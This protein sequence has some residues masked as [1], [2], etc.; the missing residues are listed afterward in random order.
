ME[1]NLHDALGVAR[2]L[3]LEPYLVAGGGAVEMAVSQL[4]QEK[5]KSVTGVKQWP[6]TALATALE[7]RSAQSFYYLLSLIYLILKGYDVT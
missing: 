3:A 5:A 6:Y 7:V 1:R 2:N 4:L